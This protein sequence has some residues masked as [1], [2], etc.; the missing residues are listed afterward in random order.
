MNRAVRLCE[1][2]VVGSVPECRSGSQQG[3]PPQSDR[4]HQSINRAGLPLKD[5]FEGSFW[6]EIQCHSIHT[7]C[8]PPVTADDSRPIPPLFAY[9]KR[10][11][12]QSYEELDESQQ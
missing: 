3:G 4:I 10:S 6:A 8:R 2:S 12:K 5:H 9:E 1:V 11:H 7:Y